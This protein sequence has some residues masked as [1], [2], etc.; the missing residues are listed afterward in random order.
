MRRSILLILS[1]T[2]VASRPLDA[3]TFNRASIAPAY[4]LDALTRGAARERV[5]RDLFADPYATVTLETVD[6]YNV[7]PYVESRTFQVVSDPRWNRLVF[8][9]AGRSLRAYDGAG[10]PLGALS[11]PRGMAVDEAN[12]VYVADA[13]NDRVLVLQASTEFGDLT[14]TPVYAI[15]G[16]SDPHGVAWSDG[17]TPFVPDDDLL[18]VTD[19]GRN[20]VAAYA[21]AAH[22][23]RLVST[24]GELGAR[25]VLLRLLGNDIRQ[26]MA[27]VRDRHACLAVER[28]L[29]REHDED[30]AHR[31]RDLANAPPAPGPDRG[32]DVVDGG[33]SSVLEAPLQAEVEARRIDAD[34]EIGPRL[35]QLPSELSPDRHD[36]AQM[37][38][39]LRVAANREL[40]HRVA[41]LESLVRHPRT[42]DA[43]AFERRA[44]RLEGADEMRAEKI[45]RGLAGHHADAQVAV[46]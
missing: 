42:A 25:L 38:E 21:L 23:G 24:L 4:G 20:R 28:L 16:L 29:E 5:G 2:L 45:A 31:A 30:M 3:G 36:L 46:H 44:A 1:L 22:S 34:E 15:D 27:H 14:L 9:E 12:R 8:G 13:G 35:Q 33:N 18:F 10:L 17:G 6:I 41:G 26:G 43:G 11:E 40:V 32:A 39:Q 37:A 19:T 7:F